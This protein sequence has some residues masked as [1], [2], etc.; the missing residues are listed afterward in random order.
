MTRCEQISKDVEAVS[1]ESEKIRAA[2]YDPVKIL[3]DFWQSASEQENYDTLNRV[4]KLRKQGVDVEGELDK[5]FMSKK[6]PTDGRENHRSH[7][8]A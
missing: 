7:G 3:Q 8:E 2:G 1:R 4:A 6:G 5:A